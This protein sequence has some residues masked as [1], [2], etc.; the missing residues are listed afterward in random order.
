MA[1][2]RP[3]RHHRSST[4]PPAWPV[5][6][7]LYS[8][9]LVELAG[10]P[11]G[12]A[13]VSP[14]RKPISTTPWCRLP[15]G[16]PP[17]Q[18]GLGPSS[19]KGKALVPILALRRPLFSWAPISADPHAAESMRRTTGQDPMDPADGPA[20]RRDKLGSILLRLPWVWMH[21]PG[22]AVAASLSAG[23]ELPPHSRILD[24]TLHHKPCYVPSNVPS[25][26]TLTARHWLP[27]CSLLANPARVRASPSVKASLPVKAMVKMLP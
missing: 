21:G 25:G 10:K 18:G 19:R 6:R 4:P 12:S 24:V 2:D 11:L 13:G 1:K 7:R 14:T 3:A 5:R 26:R 16:A 9:V 23:L 20:R 8:C 22:T 15:C 27:A 17:W